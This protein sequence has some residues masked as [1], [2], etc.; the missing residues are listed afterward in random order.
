MTT[1]EQLDQPGRQ[2]TILLC[3]Q[4]G[5]QWEEPTN[6]YL[7]YDGIVICHNKKYI[8]EI[9]DRGLECARYKELFL[10][11]DKYERLKNWKTKL[12]AAGIFYINWIGTNAY[13]F[14]LD[15]PTLI[16]EPQKKYM[17]RVTAYS[18]KEKVEKEVYLLEKNKA[19]LY[20]L[21]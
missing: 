9:K 2:K 15:D 21:T 12:D 13:I 14:N 3:Q 8:V 5:Y 19:H 10:E 7:A 1:H 4:K 6:K 17:N 16:G 11:K 18:R 20:C